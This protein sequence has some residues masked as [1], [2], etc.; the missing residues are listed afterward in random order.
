MCWLPL[1]YDSDWGTVERT[2]YEY[3]RDVVSAA[4][5]DGQY[6]HFRLNIDRSRPVRQALNQIQTTLEGNL[7]FDPS[8]SDRV[9]NISIGELSACALFP[10]LMNTLQQT[11][12]GVRLNTF[13]ANRREIKDALEQGTL[14]LAIDVSGLSTRVLNRTEVEGDDYVCELR[15]NHPQLKNRLTLERFPPRD[16]AA[17]NDVVVR[18]LP[19]EINHSN[20]WIYWYRSAEDDP[21]TRGFAL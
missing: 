10:P 5:I 17:D 13:Q 14:D 2:R 21:P 18:K 8:V 6:E 15:R 9:L 3:E 20:R 12:P 16:L 19:V 11:A 4:I 7:D 1:T